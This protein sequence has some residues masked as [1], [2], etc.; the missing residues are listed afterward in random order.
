MLR[1]ERTTTRRPGRC[2]AAQTTML[3]NAASGQ[4]STC[5]LLVV[6]LGLTAG[7][8]G[9]VLDADERAERERLRR[10]NAELRLDREF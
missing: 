5:R 6:T 4:G 7:N 9:A 10:E 2:C 1:N 3:L 8:T